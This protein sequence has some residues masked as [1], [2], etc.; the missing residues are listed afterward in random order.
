VEEHFIYLEN[1][2][3]NVALSKNNDKLGCD[4]K[5]LP[6]SEVPG[7]KRQAFLKL[8]EPKIYRTAPRMTE[9]GLHLMGKLGAIDRDETIIAHALPLWKL[10]HEVFA[11]SHEI[12]RAQ[13]AE[14]DAYPVAFHYVRE[15]DGA[16]GKHRADKVGD[17]VSRR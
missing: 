14:L 11:V 9:H 10:E 3:N 8:I 5:P 1:I 16:P 4:K 15:D 7:K 13:V 17:V 12:A 2:K 6:L